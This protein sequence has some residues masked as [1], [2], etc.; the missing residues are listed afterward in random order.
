MAPPILIPRLEKV[1]LSMRT[2]VEI[3]PIAYSLW[4]PALHSLDY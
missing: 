2:T 1:A 3:R 4:A